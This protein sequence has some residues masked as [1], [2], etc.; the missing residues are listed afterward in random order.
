MTWQEGLIIMV[1]ASAVNLICIHLAIETSEKKLYRHPEDLQERVGGIGRA[2]ATHRT[3]T[4][5]ELT[6]ALTKSETSFQIAHQALTQAKDSKTFTVKLDPF[7]V[8]IRH[9]KNTGLGNA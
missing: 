4:E 3:W 2:M 6:R 1:I 5:Q 9:P 8:R 7:K